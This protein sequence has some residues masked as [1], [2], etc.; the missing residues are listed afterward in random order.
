MCITEYDEA[1]TMRLFKKEAR[2]EGEA[3]GIIDSGIDFGLSR[4]DILSKLKSKLG[5][6]SKRRW[7]IL[8][9]LKNGNG[10]KIF[11]IPK[12]TWIR[13]TKSGQTRRWRIWPDILIRRQLTV[14]RRSRCSHDTERRCAV[15]RW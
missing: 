2:E 1:E 13:G 5:V 4:Q 3:I 15:C 8:K 14:P 12:E 11:P 10:R 6:S 7:N 9:C